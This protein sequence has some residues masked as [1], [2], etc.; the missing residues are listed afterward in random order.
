MITQ[1]TAEPVFD[2]KKAKPTAVPFAHAATRRTI[3]FS[4][5][6]DD[7]A[8][9]LFSATFVFIATCSAEEF[10]AAEAEAVAANTKAA[11]DAETANQKEHDARV[12]KLAPK[13]SDAPASAAPAAQ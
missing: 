9:H 13:T 10:S 8:L 7:G 5:A 11:A 6:A 4:Q 3:G 1:P 2:S 12:A